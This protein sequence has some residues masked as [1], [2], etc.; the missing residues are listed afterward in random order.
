VK[1]LRQWLVDMQWKLCKWTLHRC[2]M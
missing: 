2:E 1:D